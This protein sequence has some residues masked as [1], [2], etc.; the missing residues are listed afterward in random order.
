M[1]R[2]LNTELAWR[3]VKVLFRAY[4]YTCYFFFFILLLPV[5]ALYLFDLTLY[6]C[7]IVRFCCRWQ[8]YHIK[9]QS[10]TSISFISQRRPSEPRETCHSSSSSILSEQ[11]LSDCSLSDTPC[12]T[13]YCLTSSPIRKGFASRRSTIAGGASHQVRY[14]PLIP[15][16]IAALADPEHS[17]RRTKSSDLVLSLDRYDMRANNWYMTSSTLIN[18]LI[19]V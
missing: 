1:L 11:S 4:Q 12:F 15:E 18:S 5:I 16:D 8:V 14:A 17:L 13:N 2:M 10:G 7:R 19:T 9:N 3:L 6:L